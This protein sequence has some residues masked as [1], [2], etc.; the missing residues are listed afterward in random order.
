MSTKY[1]ATVDVVNADNEEQTLD[2]SACSERLLRNTL[3]KLEKDVEQ[4]GGEVLKVEHYTT[5]A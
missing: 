3:A 2:V 5:K 4:E 1:R